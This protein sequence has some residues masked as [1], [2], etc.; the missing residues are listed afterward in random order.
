VPGLSP[1]QRAE[2]ERLLHEL[3]AAEFHHGC[4]IGADAAAH[5][6]ALSLGVPAII[7]H[8]STLVNQTAEIR[9][10]AERSAV[11]VLEPRKP[12][13]RNRDIVRAVDVLIAAP[14]TAEELKHSGT[15]STVRFARRC[16]PNVRVIIIPPGE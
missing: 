2:L 16:A 15:W 4:A 8:P 6:I 3:A 9:R 5:E 10:D 11:T 7:V 1:F 13:K 14:A 12:L